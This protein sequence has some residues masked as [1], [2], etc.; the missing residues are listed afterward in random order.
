MTVPGKFPILLV[1]DEEE[2]LFIHSVMF[3][4]AGFSEVTTLS[5]SRKVLP[6]LEERSVALIVLDLYMPFLGGLELLKE[7]KDRFPQIPVIIMSAANQIELA[8]ECMKTG[9]FDYFV[10]PAEKSRLLASV[11]RLSSC[12]PCATRS[13]C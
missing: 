3:R 6:L 9:A 4:G 1:D 7:I 13:P 2:M 11:N 5:D 12:I 10:K 8:V